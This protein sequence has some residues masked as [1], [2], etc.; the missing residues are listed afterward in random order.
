MICM[1]GTGFTFR[2]RAGNRYG[3]GFLAGDGVC[4][5][6]DRVGVAP[7]GGGLCIFSGDSAIKSVKKRADFLEDALRLLFAELPEP[8]RLWPR[9]GV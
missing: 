2:L 6:A 4:L 5:I 3:G 9:W 8:V 1:S 7:G